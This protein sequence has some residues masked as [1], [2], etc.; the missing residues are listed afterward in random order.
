MAKLAGGDRR[1]IG[2]SPEVVDDIVADPALFAPVFEAIGDDDLFVRMR[3][4]DVAE[5]VT[6]RRPELL[7]GRT[8]RLLELGEIDQQEVR[9]HVAQMLPRVRLNA[10]ERRRAVALLERYL[11]DRSSIV[12]TW[13][14]NALAELAVDDAALRPHVV[15]LIETLTESGTPAMRARGRRALQRLSVARSQGA[16][17]A[18]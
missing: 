17:R 12:R 14:M 8:T 18:R 7:R 1:S 13:A 16:D 5:K 4:A 6:A 15:P 10:P 3:A 9:W 2:R 11:D